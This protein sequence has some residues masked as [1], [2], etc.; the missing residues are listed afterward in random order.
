LQIETLQCVCAFVDLI[1]NI[2]ITMQEMKY[3]KLSPI[4]HA[5]ESN[6]LFN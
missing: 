4:V 5:Y 1:C 2:C 6:T 3:V